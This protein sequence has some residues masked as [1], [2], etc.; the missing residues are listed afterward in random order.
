MLHDDTDTHR[1][2][3]EVCG[4]IDTAVD[5]SVIVEVGEREKEMLGGSHAGMASPVTSPLDQAAVETASGKRIG[6]Y[7]QSF[8][9]NSITQTLRAPTGRSN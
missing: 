4:Q 9:H 2:I 7:K 8:Q 1:E 5:F 6:P 3:D